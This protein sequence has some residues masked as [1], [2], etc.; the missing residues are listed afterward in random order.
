[1]VPHSRD[2]LGNNRSLAQHAS[3][4][5][6][7]PGIWRGSHQLVSRSASS[8]TNSAPFRRRAWNASSVEGS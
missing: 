2:R 1:M 5:H 3:H 6:G 4:N 7:N 8:R